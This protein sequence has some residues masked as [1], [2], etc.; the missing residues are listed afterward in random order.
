MP[1]RSS[2]VKS[3]EF[4]Q[5]S[6]PASAGAGIWLG[7]TSASKSGGA[8]D[9]DAG[10][11]VGA[12]VGV[13]VGAALSGVGEGVGVGLGVGADGGVG[14][15]AAVSGVGEGVGAGEGAGLGDGVA[16]AAAVLGESTATAVGAP[17]A[18]WSCGDEAQAADMVMMAIARIAVRTV[19]TRVLGARMGILVGLSDVESRALSLSRRAY[20][21]NS[22]SRLTVSP[23]DTIAF[24]L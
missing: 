20:I 24:T 22:L 21:S 5:P 19:W 6:S 9:T 15:G 2:R 23:C 16:G 18:S 10:A 1:A 13:S 12:G 8:L 11:A 3:G 17:P 7:G 4:I 14:L